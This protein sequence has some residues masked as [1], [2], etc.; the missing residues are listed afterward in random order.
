MRRVPMIMS[1]WITTRHGFL[2]INDRDILNHAGKISHDMAKTFAEA[3]YE[4]YNVTRIEQSDALESD[5]D[6][7]IKQLPAASRR[8]P[9]G[10]GKA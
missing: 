4:Q 3:Q 5:F 7:A 1:E 9:K 2:A 6:R 10:E 8:K